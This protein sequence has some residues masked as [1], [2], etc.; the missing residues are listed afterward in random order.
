[1]PG[2]KRTYG[3]GNNTALGGL[4]EACNI[5]TQ[6][7]NADECEAVWHNGRDHNRIKYIG[8][9]HDETATPDK[10]RQNEDFFIEFFRVTTADA[11][12]YM[13]LPV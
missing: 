6:G 2:R 1:M 7:K 8:N 10:A 11:E 3:S 5:L 13:D 9:V 12:R 4:N